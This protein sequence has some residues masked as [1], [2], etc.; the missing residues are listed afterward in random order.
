MRARLLLLVLAARTGVA[1]SPPHAL[2]GAAVSPPHAAAV[3]RLLRLRAG[4]SAAAD[5][6]TMESLGEAL[7][8]FAREFE[9]SPSE[10]SPGDPRGLTPAQRARERL[11]NSRIEGLRFRRAEVRREGAVAGVG[12]FASRD[13]EEGE[14]ITCYPG[15]ALVYQPTG[16]M[17]FGGHVPEALADPDRV[18]RAAQGPSPLARAA[19]LLLCTRIVDRCRP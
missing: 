19:S 12:L 18:S 11:L 5:G 16:G 7:H 15:D 3:C 4:H 14:L 13:L 9:A 17:I 8:R 2:L 6:T 10:A 1:A